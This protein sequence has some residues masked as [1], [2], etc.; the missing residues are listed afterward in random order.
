MILSY[1]D[2]VKA[3]QTKKIRFDPDISIEQIGL[4]SIDLRLGF[5]YSRFKSTATSYI[6]KPGAEGFNPADIY[7]TKD[8]SSTEDA[9]LI[10]KPGDLTLAFT[11]EKLFV[12]KYLAAAVQGK[13]TMARLGLAV[14]IT[15][16]HIHPHFGS[17][18]TLEL[19]NYGKCEI[20]LRP[21]SDTI[22]QIIYYRLSSPV[23]LHLG[24]RI[25]TYADQKELTPRRLSR[26]RS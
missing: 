11:H 10:I 12:P 17:W 2:L 19:Y 6:L 22:C 9:R 25:G 16:P 4:S 13:S 5:R 21:G 23:P 26:S 3:W 20:E 14:H 1:P 8:L 18:L 15:A 7:D 24:K